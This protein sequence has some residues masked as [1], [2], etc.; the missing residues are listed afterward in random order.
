MDRGIYIHDL[1]SQQNLIKTTLLNKSSCLTWNPMEPFNFVVGNEDGNCYQFDM[2]K[3]DQAKKLH[4]GHIGAVLSIDFAPSGREFVSGSFDKTLRIFD[5][6]K[7]VSREVYHTKRMQKVFAVSWSQDNN[8]IFSGSEET[9]IRVW[10]A[11]AYK[12]VG[13]IS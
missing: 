9:N 5:I 8:Y 7:G 12:K 2:R 1:R 10:K 11:V 3:M 6:K 13:I 4:K